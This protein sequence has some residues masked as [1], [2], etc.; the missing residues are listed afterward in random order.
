MIGKNILNVITKSPFK[1]VRHHMGCISFCA[2]KILPFAKSIEKEHWNK[3]NTY[4]KEIDKLKKDTDYTK[5]SIKYA[6][7]NGLFVNISK[8]DVINLLKIQEKLLNKI[9]Y[10]ASLLISKKLKIP[11][12]IINNNYYQFMQSCIDAC[13]EAFLIVAKLE[14]IVE[15]GFPKKEIQILN[16]MIRKLYII[17]NVSN[18]LQLDIRKMLFK[19]DQES[20]SIDIIYLYKIIDLTGNVSDISRQIAKKSKLIV[21]S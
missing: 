15:N 21:I 3:A 12:F 10:I 7:R 14:K 2:K 8:T 16:N 1:L 5:K 20:P 4:Y 17:E 9:Y 18:K 6:L 11:K 13:H 19:V